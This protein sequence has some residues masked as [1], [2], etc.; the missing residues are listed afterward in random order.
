MNYDDDIP[1]G[2]NKSRRTDYKPYNYY[3][4]LV[5]G[6][7]DSDWST[8]TFI[9]A[10]KD[11]DYSLVEE[12]KQGST[13]IVCDTDIINTHDYDAF[14]SFKEI[15]KILGISVERVRQIEAKALRKL[16]HPKNN[17]QFKTY[18]TARDKRQKTT[19]MIICKPWGDFIY[20]DI[21]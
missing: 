12:A 17:R 20:E 14:M 5:D 10:A 8:K 7:W 16:K 6:E 2:I 15:G 9:D 1:R 21:E 18:S 11:I 13:F 4:Y 19:E 3:S